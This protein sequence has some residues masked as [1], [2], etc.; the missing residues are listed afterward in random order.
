MQ[1]STLGY[2]NIGMG[3][4]SSGVSAYGSYAAGQ[5]ERA[6]GEFNAELE[7]QKMREEMQT[8]EEQFSS[9][10]GRQRMLYAAAGVDIAS[11]SPLLVLT[12]TAR[13]QR[14]EQER[15]RTGGEQRAQ[16]LRWQG[17]QASRAGTLGAMSTFLTGL[18]RAGQD[19]Y[20]ME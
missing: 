4:L 16:M 6:T 11:G 1:P 18:G 15:I 20:A 14:L 8:S 10:M 12:D 17:R 13:R 5:A 7:L 2:A 19:L 3:L 9:L